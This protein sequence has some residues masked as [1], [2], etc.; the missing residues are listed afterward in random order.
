MPVREGAARQD[1]E[2]L[3]IS[4]EQLVIEE[5]GR[6]SVRRGKDADK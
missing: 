4:S 1:N 5:F 2:Q 6:E 3:A